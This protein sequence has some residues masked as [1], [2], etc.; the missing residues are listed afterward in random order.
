MQEVVAEVFCVLKV[1]SSTKKPWF[2]ILPPE[3]NVT[4]RVTF[5]IG[6][7]SSTKPHWQL[8]NQVISITLIL[9]LVVQGVS[10]EN[11]LAHIWPL[12]K[13]T[14]VWIVLHVTIY[15]ANA[16]WKWFVMK[17]TRH[18]QNAKSLASQHTILV[19]SIKRQK[20]N[21]NF[22]FFC[23]REILFATN[24][25]ISLWLRKTKLLPSKWQQ[26]SINRKTNQTWFS[27]THVV[28]I[29]CYCFRKTI[30][31]TPKTDKFKHHYNQKTRNNPSEI[32]RPNGLCAP[33]RR[34]T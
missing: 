18:C 14:K 30:E 11:C 31:K 26:T 32:K 1:P 20:A 29:K 3:W 5:S 19:C 34:R 7:S 28:T 8:Q 23:K 6:M 2:V 15:H 27:F 10:F 21:C 13:I 33:I 4:N 17:R 24:S 16:K 9:L 12:C 22:T 25:I